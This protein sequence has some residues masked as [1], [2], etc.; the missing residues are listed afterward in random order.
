MQYLYTLDQDSIRELD[1]ILSTDLV[2]KIYAQAHSSYPDE[3]CGLLLKQGIR[4]CTNILND[5]HKA[6]PL[7]YPRNAAEG[8]VFSSEDALFLSKNINSDN[9]VKIIYHSHPDVGAYF[10]DEDKQNA[11]FDGEPIYPVDHLVIDVQSSG[12]VCSKLFR[13]ING[14]YKLIAILPGNND[15]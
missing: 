12:V 11:L 1:D 15:K 9:P 4:P 2:A 5:L 8:F 13:F 3:C 7:T 6:D 14:D 10:S